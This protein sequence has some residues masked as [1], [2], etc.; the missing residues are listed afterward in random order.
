MISK[1]WQGTGA[2]SFAAAAD[3]DVS[4][5]ARCRWLAGNVSADPNIARREFEA[6]PGL[7]PDIAK[8]CFRIVLSLPP[9]DRL[10][11]ETWTRMATAY[12]KKLGIDTDNHQNSVV[13]HLDT[14]KQHVHITVN[15]VRLDGS[16]WSRRNDGWK[17][18][19]AVAELERAFGLT[20]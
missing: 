11:D 9:G 14:A 20:L 17:G 3:Y 18:R 6:I 12:L 4:K 16:I 5:G 8:P 10:D 19:N 15:R 2:A 7:R 1:H 13:L